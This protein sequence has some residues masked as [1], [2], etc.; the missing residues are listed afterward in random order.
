MPGVCRVSV[1]I[2]GGK[3]VGA[4]NI[5]VFLEGKFL[6][7]NGDAIAGHG[8]SPHD[9]PVTANGSRKVTAM[10]IPVYRLGDKATC[11]HPASTCSP[12]LSAG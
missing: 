11:G 7:V 3:I 6:S 9:G 5:R 12:Y 8:P 4:N 2:A 1:D 10:G